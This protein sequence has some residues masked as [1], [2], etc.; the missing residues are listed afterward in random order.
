MHL[1]GEHGLHPPSMEQVAAS[2]RYAR[3]SAD[4]DSKWALV[5]SEKMT[6]TTR[7]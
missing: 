2:E 1:C 4:Y 6:P 5:L 3:S 7:A